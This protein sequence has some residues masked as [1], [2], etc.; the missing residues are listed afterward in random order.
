MPADKLLTL[1][2][3]SVVIDDYMSEY[4]L[5]CITLRCWE[6]MQSELGVAPCVLLSELNDRGIAASCEIDLCSAINMY[7]MQL[8]S[9][10]P[11]A[12]LDWNNNYGDDPDKVIL[13]RFNGAVTYEGQGH[14][15]RPQDVC[16]RLSG[17]R[18]GQ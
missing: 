15:Y 7:S 14:R 2:K 4:R 17:L 11:T 6:E 5:D 12:C 3:V 8:A 18:L 10:N 9:Q 13:L 16:Q 1:S